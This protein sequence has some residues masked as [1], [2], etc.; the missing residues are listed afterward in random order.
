MI[1]RHSDMLKVYCNREGRKFFK[2]HNLDWAD[3]VQ[4]GIESEKLLATGDVHAKR[5]VDKVESEGRICG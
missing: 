2:R 3:F 1:I 4:N 5:L